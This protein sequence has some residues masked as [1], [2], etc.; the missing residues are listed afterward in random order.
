MH[1][2]SIT[3]GQLTWQEECQQVLSIASQRFRRQFQSLEVG[4]K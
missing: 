1:G 4:L 2:D 3:P